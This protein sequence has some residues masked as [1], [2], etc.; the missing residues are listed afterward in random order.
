MPYDDTQD[1]L[2]QN[3]PQHQGQADRSVVSSSDPPSNPF[4][5]WLSCCA[6]FSKLELPSLAWT[7]GKWWKE[8]W[9]ALPWAPLLA[10]HGSPLAPDTCMSKWCSKSHLFQIMGPSFCSLFFSFHAGALLP[11]EQLVLLLETETK[12]TVSQPFHVISHYVSLCIQWRMEVLCRSPLV[13]NVLIYT[14]LLSSMAIARS[15]SSFI[16]A[17]LAFS[18]HN[19]MTPELSAS[20]FKG[21]KLSFSAWVPVKAFSL[22]RSLIFSAVSFGTWGWPAGCAFRISFLKSAG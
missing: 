8:A 21:H 1:D 3:L 19:L 22:A 20:S 15:R 12:K 13:A 16:L 17:Y 6:A 9:C 14:F 11:G 7:A 4:C 18:V 5:W 2:H 10:L